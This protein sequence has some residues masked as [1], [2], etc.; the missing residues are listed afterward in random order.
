MKRIGGLWDALVSKDNLRLAIY[1]A[2]K[3]KRNRTSIQRVLKNEDYYVNKLHDILVSGEYKTSMYSIKTIYEPKERLIYSLPFFPDRIAHR[4]IMNVLEEY[5]DKL[6]IYDSY[7]C[8]KGK[9]THRGSR[10]C[11]EFTRKYRYVYK[12]DVSKFYPNIDHA[13]LKGI[14]S[15]KLKD[16]RLLN[17]LYEIIDSANMCGTTPYGK[18]VPIGNLLSQWLGNLYLG[19]LDYFVKH[20]LKAK[21]YI[22]YCD[23]FVIFSDDK[24]W[25]HEVRKKIQAF[26]QDKLYLKLSKSSVFP[27]SR[28]VDFLG[29]RHFSTYLTLRKRTMKKWKRFFQHIE[30]PPTYREQCRL[31]CF[32]GITDWCNSFGLRK[33]L[34]FAQVQ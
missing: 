8:R 26:L 7:A 25:L 24:A 11:M 22:R 12:A 2:A 34:C 10:R 29:Y 3:G 4:A 32:K 21:A 20:V 13:I 31:A 17:L 27:V 23:D 6:L 30:L 14:I 1:K 28:G 5:W 15:R 18:N 16:K 9:G 19:E 33:E